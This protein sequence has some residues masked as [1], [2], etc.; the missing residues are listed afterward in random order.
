M[1]WT[2]AVSALL[3]LALIIASELVEEPLRARI[4]KRMNHYL[5]GYSVTL[6]ELDFHLLGFSITLRGLTI[7][8]DAHPEPPVA[9]FPHLRASVHWQEL[10]SARLVADFELNDPRIHVN[11]VQLQ[12]EAADPVPVE[13]RG[14]QEA[15]EAIYP[16]K[17]NHL[18]IHGGQITYIDQDPE[19][20]L[21]LSDLRLE[22]TNIR[23]IRYQEQPYPSPFRLEAALFKTGRV[24][25]EGHANFLSEPHPGLDAMIELRLV[26]LDD[27][28]PL[29]GHA[30]L[31]IR[32]GTV[33]AAGHLE[34]APQV[35]VATLETLHIRKIQLDYTVS[36]VTAEIEEK[37]RE[38]LRQ[39]TEKVREQ[40]LRLRAVELRISDSVL[41]FVNENEDPDYRIFLDDADITLANFSDG[42]H[43]G[44]ASVAITGLFMGSG[45]TQAAAVF[46]PIDEGSDFDLKLHIEDTSLPAI[47]DLLRAYLGLDTAGGTFSLFTEIEV[48]GNSIS[49]YIRPFF[50]DIDIPAPEGEDDKP[51]IQRLYERLVGAILT[52]LEGPEDELATHA[53]LTG[54]IDDPEAST[55]QIIVNL[56]LNAFFNI[57]LPG[58]EEEVNNPQGK[59]S[60][61]E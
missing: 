42:F 15:F 33:D 40:D 48:R 28:Q 29:A 21:N 6:P 3:L 54:T 7:R 18:Q 13:E 23:N 9:F 24:M 26:P 39:T 14:W 16:L 11:L 25:I 45:R 38:Q 43:Q 58:F 52:L 37:R 59:K 55:L 22:A 49:G 30:N 44:P 19:R 53:D 32:G 41:G 35:K 60:P 20:P 17:I 36:P 56:I 51:L 50:F 5:A 4:E 61:R 2:I 1:R 47:N 46:R 8:Q 27:L 31:F 12:Q 10:L 34:Y 57:V